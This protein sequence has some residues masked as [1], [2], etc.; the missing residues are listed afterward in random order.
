MAALLHS[1]YTGKFVNGKCPADRP[2]LGVSETES[3]LNPLNA[4]RIYIMIHGKDIMSF[5]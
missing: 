2:V 1:P 4:F 3:G 5:E